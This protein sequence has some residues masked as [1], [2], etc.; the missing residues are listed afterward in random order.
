VDDYSEPFPTGTVE[1]TFSIS[2]KFTGFIRKTFFVD[3]RGGIRMVDDYSHIEGDNRTIPFAG[4]RLSIL[5]SS[6]I[7]GI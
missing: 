1:K 7:S 2:G 5:V 6:I 3:C 4:L